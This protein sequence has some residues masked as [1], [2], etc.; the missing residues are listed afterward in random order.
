MKT[1]EVYYYP[2][3]VKLVGNIRRSLFCS[4]LIALA[5]SYDYYNKSSDKEIF[6][7]VRV[8][9]AQTQYLLKVLKAKGILFD[10]TCFKDGETFKYTFRKNKVNEFLNNRPYGNC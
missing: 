5:E 8:T 7:N 4:C 2:T 1:V 10:Y 9:K 3:S 6:E